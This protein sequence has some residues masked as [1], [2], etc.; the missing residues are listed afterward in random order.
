MLLAYKFSKKK[1][2]AQLFRPP[3]LYQAPESSNWDL[4]WEKFR[5]PIESTT[6]F[7]FNFHI[8]SQNGN[9]AI[10]IEFNLSH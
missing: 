3:L 9:A 7:F 6:I 10:K 4:L 1:F 2:P 5:K 8:T